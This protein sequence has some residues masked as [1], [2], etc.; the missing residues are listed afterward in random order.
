MKIQV[1]YNEKEHL[2]N[3]TVNKPLNDDQVSLVINVTVSQRHRYDIAHVW[4]ANDDEGDHWG[5]HVNDDMDRSVVVKIYPET[6]EDFE[7]YKLDYRAGIAQQDDKFTIHLIKQDAIPVTPIVAW[8]AGDVFEP[9][10][11]FH[12]GY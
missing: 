5:F 8:N 11:R 12:R 2:K 6:A 9:K 4:K 10:P 1:V 7:L 3:V